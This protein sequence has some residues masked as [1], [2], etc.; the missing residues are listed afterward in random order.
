MYR[1]TPA[2]TPR[3][4]DALPDRARILRIVSLF[5]GAAAVLSLGA[6][7]LL[8]APTGEADLGTVRSRELWSMYA[9][10]LFAI[11]AGIAWI[12]AAANASLTTGTP[13]EISPR[14]I[15][16][17]RLWL[18]AGLCV[19]A[20]MLA[21]TAYAWAMGV[22]ET[23]PGHYA[24]RALLFVRMA[25]IFGMS[26]LST[27]RGRKGRSVGFALAAMVTAFIGTLAWESRLP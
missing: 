23:H 21:P 4:M 19:L 8:S 3:Q 27:V 15:Q 13:V 14:F 5:L 24:R 10:A 1:D 12:T 25:T 17:Q 20:V 7:F 26:W 16:L 11:T 9:M 18:T 6:A 2:L 22:P